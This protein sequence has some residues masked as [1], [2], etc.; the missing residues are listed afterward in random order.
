MKRKSKKKDR[1]KSFDPKNRKIVKLM[2]KVTL[3]TIFA[4]IFGQG[5]NVMTLISMSQLALKIRTLSSTITVID[6]LLAYFFRA[7]EGFVCSFALY[8]MFVF[9]NQEY[10]YYCGKCDQY[11][12]YICTRK[13]RNAVYSEQLKLLKP[14]QDDHHNEHDLNTTLL[15]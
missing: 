14:N 2:T 15:H 6:A 7:L 4:V 5:F 3:L 1:H 9:N 8:C 11:L 13:V 12:Y 10:G